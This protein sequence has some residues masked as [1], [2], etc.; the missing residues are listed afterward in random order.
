MLTF[1]NGKEEF[2]RKSTNE[3]VEILFA[4][5]FCPTTAE[6]QKLIQDGESGKML[7]GIK[8]FLDDCDLSVIQFETPLTDKGTPIPKSGPNLKSPPN[9]VDFLKKGRFDVALLANNHIGDV[10]TGPVMETIDILRRNGIKTV[11]AGK[12]I[13]TAEQPLVIRKNGIRIA[14]MNVAEN[15]FGGADV[16]KPGANPLNPTRNISQIIELSRRFDLVIGTVHGGNET[17]P[18]PTP[19]M[20]DTYRAFADAGAAAVIS[21]H[22]HCPEGIEIWH[23]K[24]I[25]YSLGNFY[26]PYPGKKYTPGEFWW[27][28][29]MLKLKFDKKKAYS[30]KIIPTSFGPDESRIVPFTGKARDKFFSY[31]SEISKVFEERQEIK[32]IFDA[33]SAQRAYARIG[34]L[35]KYLSD[36][37]ADNDPEKIKALL[38]D[39]AKFRQ[40][41]VLKNLLNCETHHEMLANLFRL[42]ED[43]KLESSEKQIQNYVKYRNADFGF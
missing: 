14:I 25:I 22:T 5:D 29:Y 18:F 31:M 16:N 43:G 7:S 42:L 6:S 28:G 38:D 13:E 37:P 19:R 35:K 39:P 1:K 21:A 24:P 10:G 23:G 11:G 36:W 30:L 26:F 34:A 27:K 8:D 33:C 12:D 20:V 3:T 9:C 41:L 32:R 17:N 15:E 4:G 2:G 40:L